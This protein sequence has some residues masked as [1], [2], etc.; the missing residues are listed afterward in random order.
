MRVSKPRKWDQGGG[1]YT[2]KWRYKLSS[3]T[4]KIINSTSFKNLYILSNENNN[5]LYL[6]L[7]SNWQGFSLDGF[8]LPLFLDPTYVTSTWHPMPVSA[9][10]PRPCP[11]TGY[12]LFSWFSR[13]GAGADTTGLIND[14]LTMAAGNWSLL[15]RPVIYCFYLLQRK[16]H[17]ENVGN[18]IWK[19][20]GKYNFNYYHTYFP[21]SHKLHSDWSP[22]L[23]AWDV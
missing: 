11:A 4:R 6:K 9:S 7:N 10:E 14:W 23:C 1:N 13:V 2:I 22:G 3:Q 12:D 20:F 21:I 19:L 18:Q 8:R 17:F 16:I 5:N 15:L